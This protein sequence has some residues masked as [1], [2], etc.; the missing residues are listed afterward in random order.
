MYRVE[1]GARDLYRVGSTIALPIR[2]FDP[3]R[4]LDPRLHSECVFSATRKM[5]IIK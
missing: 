5:F 3:V 4:S 1:G 2:S